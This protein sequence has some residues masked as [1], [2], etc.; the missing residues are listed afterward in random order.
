M[1]FAGI[2]NNVTLGPKEWLRWY[3]S[4]KP[5]PPESA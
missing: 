1:T 2:A 4:V 5:L 3:L